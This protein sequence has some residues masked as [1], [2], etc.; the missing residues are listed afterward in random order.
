MH[1]TQDYLFF[2]SHRVDEL[3]MIMKL[4]AKASPLIGDEHRR[5]KL[6]DT[7]ITCRACGLEEEQQ[8]HVLNEC[9]GLANQRQR[10]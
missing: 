5:H 4:R 2:N 7:P 1:A 8:D 3:A 9:I 10:F 6:K